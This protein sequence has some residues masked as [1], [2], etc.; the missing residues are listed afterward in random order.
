MMPMNCPTPIA[1]VLLEI[2]SR[3]ILRIR[4]LAWS[5][6]ANRCIVEADHI[7]NLPNLIRDY[8]PELLTF[9]WEV[10][11]ASFVSQIPESLLEG[12]EPLWRELRP[13]VEMVGEPMSTA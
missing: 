1:T 12:F 10:E 5:G 8:S 7:H 11:R 13:Y 3:G 9:Y 2:L 6:D 4:A